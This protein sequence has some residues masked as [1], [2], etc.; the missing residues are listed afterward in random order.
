MVSMICALI[1]ST[2]HFTCTDAAPR[3][4]SIFAES[5]IDVFHAYRSVSD[6]D[7]TLRRR[8]TALHNS[9][10]DST[11]HDEVL[12]KYFTEQGIFAI[13][14]C[15][16][17]FGKMVG[18]V[19]IVLVHFYF[20]TVT[21]AIGRW[22]TTGQTRR[23]RSTGARRTEQCAYQPLGRHLRTVADVAARY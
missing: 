8:L 15:G 1:T 13:G 11:L 5:L 21:F 4:T 12:A 17:I 2:P 22:T 9:S 20:S 23:C 14:D 3:P 19:K 6:A 18:Y 7:T 16:A 10:L